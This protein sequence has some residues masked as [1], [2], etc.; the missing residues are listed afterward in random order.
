MG[1]SFIAGEENKDMRLDVFLTSELSELSRSQIQRLIE[2]GNI[3]VNNLIVKANYRLRETDKVEGELPQAQPLEVL[4]ENIP[5]DIVYEDSDIVIVN[6][7]QGMV[8]HPA[9][10]N[11]HGTLV[12]ALLYHCHDLSGINGVM[13]PG[14]VHRIDKDTSGLLLVAK[15]DFAHQSIAAQMKEHSIKREYLAL[16]HG[17]MSEPGGIVEAPIGRDKKDRQKMAVI[18]KNSKDALT[19]YTVLERFNGYTLIECRLQTGRTHQIR[20]HMAFI[21]HP[22]VGDQKYGL[23]RNNL[24][25]SGQALHAMTIGF[26]HPRTQEWLE[27]KKDPPRMFR[28]VLTELGSR[29]EFGEEGF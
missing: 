10:G 1:F 26:I 6:K 9:N 17:V 3:L 28:N 29:R 12:N 14:I 5:L 24:G 20:V 25:L 27:F 4:K 7:P 19:E 11:Y 13:R 21:N 15:N 18:T 8:V 2:D 22:V 23:K 16:V